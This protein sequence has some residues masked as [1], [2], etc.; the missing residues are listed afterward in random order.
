MTGKRCGDDFSSWEHLATKRL[1]RAPAWGP[2]G[3]SPPMAAKF[4]IL[5][6]FKV[7]ENE[8]ITQNILIFL[9]RDIH[10]Y[11]KNFEKFLVFYK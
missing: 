9:E 5:K 6:R 3:G 7:L 1:S 8:S 2:L 11:M 10:S 4:N